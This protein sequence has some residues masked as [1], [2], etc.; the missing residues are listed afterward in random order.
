MQIFHKYLKKKLNV[1]IRTAVVCISMFVVENVKKGFVCEVFS[2]S[3]RIWMNCCCE[4][5]WFRL[6][7]LLMSSFVKAF[8]FVTFE[9]INSSH[10]FCIRSLLKIPFLSRFFPVPIKSI[11]LWMQIDIMHSQIILNKIMHAK[12]MHSMS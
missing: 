8:F 11:C 10:L 9:V 5:K 7:M 12:M 3:K 6:P 1:C 2:I 4:W